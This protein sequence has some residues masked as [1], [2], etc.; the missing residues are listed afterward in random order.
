[1]TQKIKIKKKGPKK[2]KPMKAG[3]G[4]GPTAGSGLRVAVGVGVAGAVGVAILRGWRKVVRAE[5]VSA[6]G[7]GL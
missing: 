6:G 3:K 2:I 5:T 7:N 1:M 4:M